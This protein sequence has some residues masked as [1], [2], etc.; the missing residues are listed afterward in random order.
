MKK[1]I[2]RIREVARSLQ[3]QSAA[4]VLGRLGPHPSPPSVLDDPSAQGQGALDFGQVPRRA[5]VRSEGFG[6]DL[7]VNHGCAG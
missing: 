2:L 5:V 6:L 1:I 7:L 3:T 4:L